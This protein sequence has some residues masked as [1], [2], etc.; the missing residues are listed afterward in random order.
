MNGERCPVCNGTHG[1]ETGEPQAW[2]DWLDHCYHCPDCGDDWTF[3]ERVTDA[4][5][6]PDND[7]ACYDGLLL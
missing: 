6:A 7:P 3:A 4:P 5:D 2:G 1:Y